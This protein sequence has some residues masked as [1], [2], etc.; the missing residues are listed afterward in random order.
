MSD[1][2]PI[3]RNRGSFPAEDPRS[4]DYGK[5]MSRRRQAQNVAIRKQ[6]REERLWKRR[7]AEVAPSAVTVKEVTPDVLLQYAQSYLQQPN[8]TNLWNLQRHM[9]VRSSATTTFLE[10]LLEEQVSKCQFMLSLLTKHIQEQPR[11]NKQIYEAAFKILLDMSSLSRTQKTGDEDNYYGRPPPR[12]CDLIIDTENLV[13]KLLEHVVQDQSEISE[14]ISNIVGNLLQ[15]APSRTLALVL[16]IWAPLVHRLPTTAYLCAAAVRQDG[17]HYGADFLKDLTPDRIALLLPLKPMEAAW[18]LEGLSRRE[19]AA[20]D[21]MCLNVNLLST[22]VQSL[23]QR[24]DDKSFLVPALKA[25]YNFTCQ[26]RNVPAFLTLPDRPHGIIPFITQLLQQGQV[27]NV[28]PVAAN[29]LVPAGLQSHP[30]TTIAFPALVPHLIQLV[31][32]NHTVFHWKREA[33]WALVEA[34]QNPTAGKADSRLEVLAQRY[35]WNEQLSVSREAFLQAITDLLMGPDLEATTAVM[36]LLDKLLR[37]VPASRPEFEVAAGVHCLEQIC[38][39]GSNS[40]DWEE[41]A[42][43]ASELL[44]D[45]FDEA[46]DEDFDFGTAMGQDHFSFGLQPSSEAHRFDFSATAFTAPPPANNGAGRGR[47]RGMT[48]PSWMSKP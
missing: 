34:L 31:A 15:D 47:G 19:Q 42:N 41:A 2:L 8:P 25:V 23:E 6:R 9:A 24:M 30:S 11:D 28:L 12:W 43:L 32:S 13:P 18:V 26:E 16:P 40:G 5:H 37:M 1:E 33:T 46:L 38:V 14:T 3:T 36:H 48:L 17:H 20:I 29:L 4:A 7:Q 22:L 27:M 10:R 21:A 39:R 35:L 45:F 44:D